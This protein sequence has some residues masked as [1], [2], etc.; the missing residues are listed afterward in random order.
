MSVAP[1]IVND[2]SYVSGINHNIHIVWQAQYSVKWE[3]DSCCSV[4]WK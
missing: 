3:G 1:R 4:H 2:I